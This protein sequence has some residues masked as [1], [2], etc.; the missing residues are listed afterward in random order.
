[1][2]ACYNPLLAD[3]AAQ[4]QPT[5]QI[6]FA[7]CGIPDI[8]V[9]IRPDGR[10]RKPAAQNVNRF[11]RFAKRWTKP[12]TRRFIRLIL[13][14]RL[15]YDQQQC[16]AKMTTI[17]Q[18][19]AARQQGHFQAAEKA[20]RAIITNQP[21]NGPALNL[22][23]ALLLETGRATE[24]EIVIRKSLEIDPDSHAALHNL[25]LVLGATGR[26]DQAQHYFAR[27]IVKR[28]DFVD[29]YYNLGLALQ[30]CGKPEE[31]AAVYRRTISLQ[32]DHASAL[33]NL[34]LIHHGRE[35]LTEAVALYRRAIAA[36]PD[37]ETTRANL[38][39]AL[40]ALGERENA[41]AMFRDAL[42]RNPRDPLSNYVLAQVDFLGQDIGESTLKLTAALEGLRER[43]DW[44]RHGS[45]DASRIPAY[46]MPRYREALSAVMVALAAAGIEACLLCGTL[47]GAMRDGDFIW[48]DK[49]M[50]FGIDASVTPFQLDAALSRDPRFRRTTGLADDVILPSYRFDDSVAIDFFRLY[51][52]GETL[53]YGL[54]WHGQLVKWRHRRFVLQDFIFLGI[55]TKIPDDHD[56]Y[57]TEAYGD[58]RTPNPYFAVWASPNIEGGFPPVSRCI[59]Y[60]NIFKAAW[61]GDRKRAIDLC[62]QALALDPDSALVADMRRRMIAAQRQIQ[63]WPSAPQSALLGALDDPFDDPA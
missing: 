57:L 16:D 52:E 62:D 3:A 9:N 40:L 63:P 35:Q 22:L 49:D 41:N 10:C 5:A 7:P 15:C 37:I 18:A 31:A 61:S 17:E 60:A 54:Y 28:P 53:W 39:S 23:G 1:M 11:E 20:C 25:G 43:S 12:A 55:P 42:A 45:P 38:G 33:N 6:A 34:A 8:R 46:N 30:S 44:L 50:D 32:P 59:A 27:A 14:C 26:P 4:T 58:W 47:L 51:P 24:A 48:F 21:N 19:I 29:A 13:S 56:L 36:N 2:I